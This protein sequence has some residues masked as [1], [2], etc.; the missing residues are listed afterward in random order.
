MVYQVRRQRRL[1]RL[2]DE[3]ARQSIRGDPEKV[4]NRTVPVLGRGGEQTGE[5][6]DGDYT[7]L[8][9]EEQPDYTK[10]CV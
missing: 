5:E 2:Q 8:E 6:Q 9:D 10:V 7:D 4:D 3:E 1:S